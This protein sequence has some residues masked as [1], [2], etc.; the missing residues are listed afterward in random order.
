MTRIESRY[1]GRVQGVGFR[2][3]V[4]AISASFAVSGWVRNEADG[5]VMVVAEGAESEVDAFLESIQTRMARNIR[6]VD[7]VVGSAVGESGF[8][9]R[10]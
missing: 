9:I 5:S 1:T 10:R 7:R 6:S 2:A 4:R 8:D 3:A